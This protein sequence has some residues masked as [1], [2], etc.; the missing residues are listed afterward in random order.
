MN[1]H[2]PCGKMLTFKLKIPLQRREVKRHSEK[3]FYESRGSLF[4]LVG[5][6]TDYGPLIRWNIDTNYG[7][8][9]WSLVYVEEDRI[10]LLIFA[11][12]E[13]KGKL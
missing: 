4:E 8:L 6:G 2:E 9:K 5:D 3:D 13:V 11:V 12:T 1:F 10:L 7:K